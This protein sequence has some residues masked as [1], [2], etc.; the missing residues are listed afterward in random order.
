MAAVK[1]N[2]T[3]ETDGI[4]PKVAWPAIALFAIGVVMI[5]LHVVTDEDGDTL[6]TLGLTAIG[7]SG[8][9]GGLGYSAPPAL[10]KKKPVV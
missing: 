9:T 2:P 8:V 1:S 4:S 10:Q 3:A 5:V 7:A 6:L